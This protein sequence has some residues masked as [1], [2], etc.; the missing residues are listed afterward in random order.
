MEK[1]TSTVVRD[2]SKKNH[3]HH[4][5]NWSLCTKIYKCAYKGDFFSII[6]IRIIIY[7]QVVSSFLAMQV[8]LGNQRQSWDVLAI[9]KAKLG[10]DLAKSICK[11]EGYCSIQVAIAFHRN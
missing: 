1:E 5:W 9:S 10:D 11:D 4:I 8:I 2:S 3:P 7:V 6:V